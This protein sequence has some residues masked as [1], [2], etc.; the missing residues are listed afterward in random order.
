MLDIS[1]IFCIL[2]EQGKTGRET[3]VLG[4]VVWLCFLVKVFLVWVKS[5]DFFTSLSSVRCG[6]NTPSSSAFHEIFLHPLLGYQE[7]WALP[8]DEYNGAG[9]LHHRIYPSQQYFPL[10]AGVRPHPKEAGSSECL[11][12]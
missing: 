7:N 8:Q 4:D 2:D 6:I 5:V 9:G 3:Q 12:R 11:R 1:Q 10:P